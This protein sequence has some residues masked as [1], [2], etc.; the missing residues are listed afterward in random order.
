MKA[1]GGDTD[2]SVG[3]GLSA[4]NCT[5]GLGWTHDEVGGA[6]I[7]S[8]VGTVNGSDASPTGRITGSDSLPTEA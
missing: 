3:P 4:A 8:L 6:C 5:Q 2:R 1:A 7:L